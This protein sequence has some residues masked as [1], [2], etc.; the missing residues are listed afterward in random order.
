MREGLLNK[1]SGH[2]HNLDDV[3][4]DLFE[5]IQALLSGKGKRIV[6]AANRIGAHVARRYADRCVINI[7]GAMHM[8]YTHINRALMYN[9]SKTI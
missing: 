9:I 6:F 7:I 4:D 1:D 3:T 5:L 8:I 2:T